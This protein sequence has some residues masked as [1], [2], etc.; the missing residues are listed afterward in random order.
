MN[1]SKFKEQY[2]FS[3]IGI[4]ERMAGETVFARCDNPLCRCVLHREVKNH[5]TGFQGGVAKRY[6]SE[7]CKEQVVD[8]KE[9][10]TCFSCG[11]TVEAWRNKAGR[12]SGYPK[13]CNPCRVAKAT[14]IAQSKIKHKCNVCGDEVIRHHNG[15]YNLHCNSCIKTKA[16]FKQVVNSAI[17]N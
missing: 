3:R 8:V 6:C 15:R 5:V 12:V 9:L 1:D 4:V 17:N 16:W 11:L 14:K 10:H 13:T 7:W 2:G